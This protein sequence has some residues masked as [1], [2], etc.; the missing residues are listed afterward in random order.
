MQHSPRSTAK[1]ASS[2]R[3]RDA[4]GLEAKKYV[5][6]WSHPAYVEKV[7]TSYDRVRHLETYMRQS[8]QAILQD[9]TPFVGW[10]K[11]VAPDL[12]RKLQDGQAAPVVVVY[13]S[14]AVAVARMPA[15]G[16]FEEAG[17]GEK[18]E[19]QGTTDSG[20]EPG[21]R[22]GLVRFFQRTFQLHGMLQST[23]KASPEAK[24]LLTT[25]QEA[26]WIAYEPSISYAWQ[27]RKRQA[28]K[29]R[30]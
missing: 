2:C 14:V 30:L 10:Q 15:P 27:V 25:C 23:T 20:A 6:A 18:E 3:A 22:P 26:G 16:I 4:T 7:V 12:W 13:P 5:V 28:L 21:S 11:I 29:N 8:R 9:M 1:V 19:A 24:L 17:Y